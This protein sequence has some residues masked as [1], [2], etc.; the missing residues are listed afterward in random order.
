MMVLSH[1]RALV[2]LVALSVSNGDANAPPSTRTQFHSE[3]KVNGHLRAGEEE[4]HNNIGQKTQGPDLQE[5]A[6]FWRANAQAALQ[7]QLKVDQQIRMAKN[8][9]FFLGDGMSI[10]TVTASRIL[11]GQTSGEW[12]RDSLSWEAFP[13]SALIKTYP[14]NSQVADSACSSTAYL[15]GVKGNLGTIGVDVNVNRENCSAMNNPEFQTPSIAKW[16]QVSG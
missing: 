12:E 1:A 7:E 15:C 10:S 2:L 16:Y 3:H 5:D 13:Y 14:T 11:K 9:I 4:F 8:I 6:E